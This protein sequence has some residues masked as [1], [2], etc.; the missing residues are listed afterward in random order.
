[1]IRN[2]AQARQESGFSLTEAARRAR[3]CPA[4]LRRI[5]LHGKAPYVLATRLAHLYSCSVNLSLYAPPETTKAATEL[6]VQEPVVKQGSEGL[7]R[8]PKPLPDDRK[9]SA[10]RCKSARKSEAEQL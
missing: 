9:P 7:S 6:V 10:T 1:V 2:A 8:R 5:E 4:Y 3:V